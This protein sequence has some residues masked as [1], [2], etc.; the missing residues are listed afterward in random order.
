MMD[1]SSTEFKGV[2]QFAGVRRRKAVADNECHRSLTKLRRMPVT[3]TICSRKPLIEGLGVAYPPAHCGDHRPPAHTVAAAISAM[4]CRLVD[5][6]T[7]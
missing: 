3:F 4:A 6:I 2:R 7:T 1:P 5:V